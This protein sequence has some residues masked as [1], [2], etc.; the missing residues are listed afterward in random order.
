[1][2]GTRREDSKQ[3]ITKAAAVTL[4]EDTYQ[5]FITAT[6]AA[7]ATGEDGFFLLF[8]SVDFLNEDNTETEVRLRVVS[9]IHL[10]NAAMRDFLTTLL[11]DERCRGITEAIME[12]ISEEKGNE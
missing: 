12:E 5:P 8:S 9:K 3:T 10:G 4:P 2:A 11:R 6:H 1:M 7:F